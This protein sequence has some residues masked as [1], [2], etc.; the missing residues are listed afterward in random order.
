MLVPMRMGTVEL[1][2][3]NLPFD[4][5]RS[6]CLTNVLRNATCKPWRQPA[7]ERIRIS[8]RVVF[9]DHAFLLSIIC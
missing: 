9:R 4:L 2:M 7:L 1:L 3:K 8:T 5:P 6:P